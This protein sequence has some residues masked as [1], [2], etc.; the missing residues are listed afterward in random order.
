MVVVV[1]SHKEVGWISLHLLVGVHNIV[2]VELN[3]RERDFKWDK[4]IHH[5][6]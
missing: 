2:S 5:G 1:A 6:P 3:E 4:A